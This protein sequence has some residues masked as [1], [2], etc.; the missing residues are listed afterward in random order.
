MAKKNHVDKPIHR[1]EIQWHRGAIF[2]SL[3]IF[4]A[5]QVPSFSLDPHRPLGQ[6]HHTSWNE[7]SGLSGSVYALAQTEDGFLWVGTSAGLY[8]FDG[9]VFD[10]YKPRSGTLALSEVKA[11][12]ATNDDGL[13]VGMRNSITFLKD[14]VGTTYTEHEGFPFGRVRS[15]ART[16]DGAVW[17]AVCGGLYAF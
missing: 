12:L 3:L 11:L 17:A 8:R 9:I 14:G 6:L 10:R 5:L 16:R 7:S 15:I 2:A 13:W 1:A 4:F